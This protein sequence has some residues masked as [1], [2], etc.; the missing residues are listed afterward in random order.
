V[1]ELQISLPTEPL[2]I[3]NI[4][5]TPAEVEGIPAPAERR[6]SKRFPMERAVR[7]SLL[8]KKNVPQ[9]WSMGWSTE[10]SSKGILFT[11][12][13]A[14]PV[15]SRLLVEIDWPVLLNDTTSLK[16]AVLGHVVRSGEG[17]A[18]VVFSQ[19]HFRT[20]SSSSALRSLPQQLLN[21]QVEQST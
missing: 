12:A 10:I 16:L 8:S 6:S 15:G 5:P 21:Q 17:R 7:Y 9:G 13:K 20:Q 18:A 3:F 4:D 2:A 1:T 19:Y 11:A 14:L